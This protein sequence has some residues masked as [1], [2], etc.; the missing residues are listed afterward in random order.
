MLKTSM[1]I[2]T[3][4]KVLK[5]WQRLK[6]EVLA[7]IVPMIESDKLVQNLIYWLIIKFALEKN[8]Y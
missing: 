7:N 8:C 4:F 3:V 2:Y 5:I 6:M 1:V